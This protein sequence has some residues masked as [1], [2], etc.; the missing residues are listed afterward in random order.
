MPDWDQDHPEATCEDCGRPNISWSVD[1]DRWNLATRV[2]GYWNG[3][4]CPSCFVL[5]HEKVTGMTASWTLVPATPFR[6]A[7]EA[8]R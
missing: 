2:D 5:R 3:V 6:W 4:L 8:S 1:S 7:E